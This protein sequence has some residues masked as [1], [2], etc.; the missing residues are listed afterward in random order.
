MKR[1]KENKKPKK[2]TKTRKTLELLHFNRAAFWGFEAL[3][4]LLGIS[5]FIPFLYGSFDLIM[6]IAGFSYLTLENVSKLFRHPVMYV[7]ILLLFILLGLFAAMDLS[8]VIYIIHC[9]HHHKKTTAWYAFRFGIRNTAALFKKGSRRM[10]FVVYLF[11]PFFCFSQIPELFATYSLPSLM[12]LGIKNESR[13]F[14]GVLVVLLILAVPFV[15][16]LYS[17]CYFTLENT[18]YKTAVQ[19]S[20]ALGKDHRLKDLAVIASVQIACYLLYILLLALGI[21]A[22]VIFGRFFRRAYIVSAASVSLLKII[23]TVLGFLFSLIGTPLSAVAVCV[24]FYHHKE[25][26]SEALPSLEEVHINRHCVMSPREQAWRE[27]HGRLLFGIEAA[28]LLIGVGICSFYVYQ[29]HKGELNL[30]I[31][32]IKT[33]EVTA[34]RGASRYFPENTMAAFRGAVESGADWIELDVHESKDGQIFVMHDR[35]FKRTTGVDAQAWSLTY[36]EISK[37]D[38]GSLFGRSF[39][40]EKIPLL[41]E[42]IEF[43]REN[44]IRLNIEIKPSSG[45]P[46]LERL[47]VDLIEEYD[48][49]QQCVVTSQSYDSIKKVKQM[50]EEIRTVYV[51]GLAYGNIYRL[52]Y[53]D[54]FSIRSSSISEALVSRIHNK[55]KQIYAWTVNTRDAINT[56][57]DR[58]VDNIITDDV[59]LAKKCIG[60]KL[61]TDTVNDFIDFLNR[62]LRIASYHLWGK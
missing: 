47:L 1:Q 57:I 40:G 14:L 10:F 3:Y 48:F 5:L 21:I 46:D 32:Y 17:F 41:S 18:G 45:E 60:R 35:N 58:N 26:A 34:H 27:N 33:M 61:T 31:E 44:G 30:D 7:W 43:A 54:V 29:A 56:M 53:A 38:A 24:L 50:D 16:R 55:G 19:K 22:V 51:M 9:S 13:F 2:Q 28:V 8:S 59:P 62:Q 12:L 37:L 4:K 23:L 6:H 20:R 42:V 52:E 49:K 15:H 11:L 25:E 39:V 36:D